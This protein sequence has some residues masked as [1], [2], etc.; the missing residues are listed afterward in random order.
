MANEDVNQGVSSDGLNGGRLGRVV[1]EPKLITAGIA[2]E[3]IDDQFE[4]RRLSNEA[5]SYSSTAL[6]NKQK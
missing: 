2:A 1:E 4:G 6:P 5:I 3:G